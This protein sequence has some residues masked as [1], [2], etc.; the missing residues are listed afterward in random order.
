MPREQRSQINEA[1]AK[2]SLLT[3]MQV[4]ERCRMSLRSVRRCIASGGLVV[5]RIGRAV[6]IAEP[7]LERFLRRHRSKQ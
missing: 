4:A 2:P 7:D 5:H 3:A 6:R 1:G